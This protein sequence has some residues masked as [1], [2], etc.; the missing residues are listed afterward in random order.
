MPYCAAT[1][2]KPVWLNLSV[3]ARQETGRIAIA[4]KGLFALELSPY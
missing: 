4:R 1:G 2:K 3:F